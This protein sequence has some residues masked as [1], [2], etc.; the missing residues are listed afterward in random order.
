MREANLQYFVVKNSM[1]R[2]ASKE[3]GYDFEEHLHGTTAIALSEEDPI[4]VS[5]ILTKYAKELKDESDFHIK[6]GFLEGK[7]IDAELINEYGTLPTREES[8][9]RLLGLLTSPVRM[10]AISLKL[11]AEKQPEEK[12]SE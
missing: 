12:S 11:I 10:L 6:V 7:V 2:F 8:I 3:V 9:G 5:K 1:L 4:V